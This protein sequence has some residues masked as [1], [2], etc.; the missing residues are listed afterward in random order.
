MLRNRRGRHQ[1]ALAAGPARP[2]HRGARPG[3][4]VPGHQRR[5]R[6]RRHAGRR[7]RPL[8]RAG[9]RC[10]SCRSGSAATT[11]RP[12]CAPTPSA[13]AAAV[14]DCVEDW[15]DVYRPVLGRRL[16]FAG[17]E[18][19][20]LAERPF[21]AAEAYEGFAMHE[22][23]VGMARTFELELFGDKADATG[24]P[25]GLLRLGRRL[26]LHRRRVRALPRHPGH[27]RPAPAGAARRA[28]RPVG[29][30]TGTYGAAGAR[31]RSWPASA[32]PTCGSCPVDNQ[33]FGGT[34]GGHRP[35]GGGGPRPHAGRRARGPPLPAARRLPVQRPLPRRHHARGPAPPGRDH[36]HRRPRAARARS[37]H[38][39]D[40]S[41]RAR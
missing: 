30:L 38:P 33:F 21:P 34:T 11:P 5:R 28:R 2:R 29:I 8:P 27:A 26:R 31:A 19:Y 41:R 4:G 3:R 6:A 22:D 23:G 36:P 16:V 25:G 40:T 7:A 9:R 10:A 14:V 24:T 35:A 20:L 15:Q 39:S 32:A 18:Y 12:A 37:A 17:D 13:E 1:P